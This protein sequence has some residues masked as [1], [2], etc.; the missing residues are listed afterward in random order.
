[1]ERRGGAKVEGTERGWG[2]GEEQLVFGGVDWLSGGRRR[3]GAGWLNEGVCTCS[4][5]FYKP[6]K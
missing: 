3:A 1:M 5:P 6:S 4:P 2:G